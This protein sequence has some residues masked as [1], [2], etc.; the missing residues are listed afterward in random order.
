MV[1]RLWVGQKLYYVRLGRNPVTDQPIA[2][3]LSQ[4]A[5]EPG[6]PVKRPKPWYLSPH[7]LFTVMVVLLGGIAIAVVKSR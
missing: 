7:A 3:H 6:A 1:I 4:T 5:G 2:R